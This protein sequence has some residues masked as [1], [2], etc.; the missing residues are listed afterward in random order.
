MGCRGFI[1]S[2]L[3]FAFSV[4][5]FAICEQERSERDHFRGLVNGAGTTSSILG[6]G[7]IVVGAVIGGPFGLLAGLAGLVPGPSG[8]NWNRILGEKENNLRNCE[9]AYRRAQQIAQEQEAD[10]R[11]SIL[12]I[13]GE[14]D[15]KREQIRAQ[16]EA[17]IHEVVAE[18]LNEQFDLADPEV[19]REINERQDEIRA[20]RNQILDELEHERERK[21]AEI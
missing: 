17:Q 11:E 2:L 4:N 19:Q 10:R 16:Y 18:F 14:F 12:R 21:V 9:E 6:I 8:E 1:V 13:H 20:Q 5:S 7:G 15:Q 3:V